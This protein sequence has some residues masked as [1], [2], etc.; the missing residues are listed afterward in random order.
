M[1]V[2]MDASDIGSLTTDQLL[3]LLQRIIQELTSRLHSET[4]R[5]STEPDPPVA[6]SAAH[7]I[8][9]QTFVTTQTCG[10]YCDWCTR[11]CTRHTLNHRH[12]SCFDHRH[13]R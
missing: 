10:H 8:P 5:A 4:A 12:H 6:E 13:W 3:D 2:R 1:H 9:V 7:T 11:W